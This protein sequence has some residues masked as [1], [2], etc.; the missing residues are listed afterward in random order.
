[1]TPAPA[2]VLARQRYEG[3]KSTVNA[4][5]SKERHRKWAKAIKQHAL[6]GD[7]FNAKDD[8]SKL[9]KIVVALKAEVVTAGLDPDVFDFD[10]PTIGVQRDTL[11]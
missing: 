9:A 1:M 7:Y 6:G 10:N 4:I 11:S 3:A 8:V 5:Y 2:V